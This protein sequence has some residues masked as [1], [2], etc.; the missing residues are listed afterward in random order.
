MKKIIILCTLFFL[1][2]CNIKEDSKP[3]L[4]KFN[5]ES[6]DYKLSSSLM[7]KKSNNYTN[8]DGTSQTGSLMI[9]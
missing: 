7:F 9:K 2:G 5:V 8:E 6:Y 1:T 3:V 4:Y